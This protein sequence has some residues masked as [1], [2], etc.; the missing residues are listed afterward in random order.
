MELKIMAA[1]ALGLVGG[2]MFT[3]IIDAIENYAQYKLAAKS[4]MNMIKDKI[5]ESE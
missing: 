4:A 3:R 2:M 5:E 1:V